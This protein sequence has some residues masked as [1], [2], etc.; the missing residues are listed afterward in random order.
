MEPPVERDVNGLRVD[1]LL[2]AQGEHY[3]LEGPCGA[4]TITGYTERQVR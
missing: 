1:C 2:L 3:T 4:L